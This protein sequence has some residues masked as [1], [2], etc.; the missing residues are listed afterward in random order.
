L[1][2]GGTAASAAWVVFALISGLPRG[3]G[4]RGALRLRFQQRR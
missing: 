4:P 3:G 2:G 1:P